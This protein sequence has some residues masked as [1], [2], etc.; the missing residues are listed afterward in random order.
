MSSS[1]HKFPYLT[2]LPYAIAPEEHQTY[3]DAIKKGLFSNAAAG[4]WLDCTVWTKELEE[5]A[6][7]SMNTHRPLGTW[8]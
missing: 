8:I 3:L 5:H 1:S 2:C 6:S 4:N 7:T